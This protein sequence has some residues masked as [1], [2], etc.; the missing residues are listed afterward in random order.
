MSS[1]DAVKIDWRV[2]P[3]FD[4]CLPDHNEGD[5]LTGNEVDTYK[6]NDTGESQVF[7][8]CEALWKATAANRLGTTPEGSKL[9]KRWKDNDPFVAAIQKAARMR[10]DGN[11][12]RLYDAAGNLLAEKEV[13]E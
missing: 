11:T 9:E 2:S 5:S 8:P 3:W 4:F 1:R 13:S 12:M 7:D 6:V 10:K